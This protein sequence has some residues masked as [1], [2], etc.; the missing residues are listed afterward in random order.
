MKNTLIIAK[1]EL[2]AF[3]TSPIFY[4]ITTVFLCL[5]SFIFINLLNYFGTVSFQANT[6]PQETGPLSINE[7]VIE[8]SFQNM[9]VIF[10]L[11]IPIITMRSFSEEQK[12]KTIQLLLAAPLSLWEIVIGK[13]LA[14]MGVLVLMLLISSYNMIFVVALGTPDIGPI[15]TGYLGVI[16]LSGCFI[17]AGILASSLTKNQVIAAVLGFG[18]ALFSW[19]IGWAATSVGDSFAEVLDYLSLVAHLDNFLKGILDTRDIVY[20]LSLISFFLFL[21]HR[22]LDSRR[23][24]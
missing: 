18:F 1:R 12:N 14:C 9:S 16:L 7:W 11:M 3:F 19:I 22:V 10:L 15:L 8:S 17:S 20:Y 4:V 5:Y 21:T 2:G 23:W 24:R 6:A 13:F